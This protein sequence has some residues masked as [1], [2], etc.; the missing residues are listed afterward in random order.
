M[1]VETA[2]PF[3]W[4]QQFPL[5]GGKF[6]AVMGNPPYDVI[7]KDRG[8]ASWPHD[9]FREYLNKTSRLD[10]AKGGKLNMFRFFLVQALQLSKPSGRIGMIMPMSILAD[11]SCKETRKSFLDGMSALEIDA[12]PQ[13]DNKNHRVFYEAK[14]STAILTGPKKSDGRKKVDSK[15]SLRVFPR[16]SFMDNPKYAELKRSE[17]SVLDPDAMP[18]PVCDQTAWN[19]AQKLARSNAVSRLGEIE[20]ISIN[21]GEINQTIYR[22]FIT[23]NPEHARLLKGVEVGKYRIKSHLSQG[24]VEWLDSKRYSKSHSVPPQVSARRIATQRI[25]GVDERLRIVATITEPGWFFA[26]STNSILVSKSCLYSAEYILA[27]LNSK[28]FQWRFKVTSTN[29]NVGTNEL[30]SLPVRDIHSDDTADRKSYELIVSSVKTALRSGA[31]AE[32]ASSERSRKSAETAMMDA[33]GIIDDEIA[34][35]YGLTDEEVLI[36][37]STSIVPQAAPLSEAAWVV[38]E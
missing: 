33:V 8:E 18:I 3:S 27:L 10:A 20:G 36:V 26:D 25:T 31:V 37:E 9:L 35:L 24:E 5:Y 4:S 15:I 1:G 11:V 30:N 19:L 32:E 21:R 23:S 7:E 28:L 6:D 12:F 17:L 34:K 13:K 29:N 38:P 2:K 22:K 16:N 14:L